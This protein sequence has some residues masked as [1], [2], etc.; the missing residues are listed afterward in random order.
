MQL[1]IS[2][3]LPLTRPIHF[4][5]TPFFLVEGGLLPDCT[6]GSICNKHQTFVPIVPFVSV[7]PNNLEQHIKKIKIWKT[8]E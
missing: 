5:E 4:V 2:Y 8:K 3:S 6:V 1:N 7:L